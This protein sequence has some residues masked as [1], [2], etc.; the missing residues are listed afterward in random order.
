[1]VIEVLRREVRWVGPKAHNRHSVRE[2]LQFV[3]IADGVSKRLGDGDVGGDVLT[4]PRDG[5][6]ADRGGVAG[7][8]RSNTG[9]RA[10]G[11][12]RNG[13]AGRPRRK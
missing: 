4:S 10:S 6:I 7:G 9:Q 13:D 3:R 12:H 11:R 8:A 2:Q 1:M 5:D